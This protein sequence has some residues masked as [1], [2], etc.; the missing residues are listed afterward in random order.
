MKLIQG[1]SWPLALDLKVISLSV[2]SI[3]AAEDGTPMA[4]ITLD[5]LAEENFK[6]IKRPILDDE[7]V[8]TGTEL[9]L[10]EKEIL[11][12]PYYLQRVQNVPGVPFSL[13]TAVVL[14]S[15]DETLLPGINYAIDQAK[16]NEL[17][18]GS[19]LGFRIDISKVEL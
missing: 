16:F 14:A 8:E 17:F 3:Y 10:G 12:S 7:G 18:T 15:Q 9:V 1:S 19:M 5:I 11:G 2:V 6:V 13:V 4:N